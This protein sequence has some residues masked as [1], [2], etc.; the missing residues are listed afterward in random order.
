MSG[1]IPD[2]GPCSDPR[3]LLALALVGQSVSAD[4]AGRSPATGPA[5]SEALGR[6]IAVG[7]A[8]VPGPRRSVRSRSIDRPDAGRRRADVA[9]VRDERRRRQRTPVR[10]REERQDQDRVRAAPCSRHVPRHPREDLEGAAS[11]ASSASRSTR[12]TR[13]TASSTSTTRTSRARSSIAQLPPLGW[14]PGQGRPDRV[15][16]ARGSASRS[17][18]TTAGC[19]PSGRTATSTSGTGDGGGAG[20]PGNRAQNLKSLLGKILRIDVERPDGRAAVPDPELEPVR[21]QGRPRPD[22]GA[23]AAQPVAVLVRL[24]D[25]RPV[26]R[27]RRPGPLGGDRPLAGGRRW[28]PGEELRLARDGGQ[29]LLPAVVRVQPSRARSCRSRSTATPRAARSPAATSTAAPSTRTSSGAT[30]SATSARAGSG[31]SPPRARP[32]QSPHLLLDSNKMISSFGQGEDGSLYLTDLGG[33]LYKIVDRRGLLDAVGRTS[34]RRRR[35]VRAVGGDPD[36]LGRE[37]EPEPEDERRPPS[38]ARTTHPTET[39]AGRQAVDPVRGRRR[40]RVRRRR[41][42][43]PSRARTRRRGRAR[44]RPGRSRSSPAG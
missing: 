38:S 10:R 34:S 23:R 25:R 7:R 4:G 2:R 31:R 16:P 8:A 13:R 11:A 42:R 14:R 41:G 24:G 12:T 9:A 3:A 40:A 1:R 36:R 28:R 37:V 32:S 30:C 15:G 27:R 5:T 29:G 6:A 17:R 35:P 18:T 26:D 19:S 22:L 20:D 44:R 33:G 39:R 21:R 43:P